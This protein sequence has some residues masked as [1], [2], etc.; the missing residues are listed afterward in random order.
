MNAIFK[1]STATLAATVFATIFAPGANAGCGE[2]ER[3]QAASRHPSSTFVLVADNEPAG[4]AVVGFWKFTFVSRNNPGIPDGTVLDAG[5]AQWHS[6]GT[7]I[8]NSSRPPATQSFC[9]GVWKKTGPSSFKLNHF[10][11]SFDLSGNSVGGSNIREEITVEHGGDK[12]TGTFTID[13][14]DVHGVHVRHIAG[15]VTGERITAD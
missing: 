7:E 8:M 1:L 14:F 15:D 3:Q 5:Y 12:Y 9:L 2:I 6:D 11:L 10:A 4:A 13:A